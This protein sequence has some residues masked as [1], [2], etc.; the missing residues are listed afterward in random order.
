MSTYC[1]DKSNKPHLFTLKTKINGHEV[2]ILVDGGADYTLISNSL[3][4]EIKEFSCYHGTVTLEINAV[5]GCST[6][7]EAKVYSMT[8]PTNE[9][10]INIT[11]Y[12]LAQVP[13]NS[14]EDNTNDICKVWPNLND[15]IRQ[16]VIG[17]RFTGPADI[18]IG[19]DNY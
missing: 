16:Q 2:K 3:I 18:L 14:E 10:E 5:A 19:Q 15:T 4:H 8:I 13:A 11:G 9:T 12:R 17:N 1:N 7:A 6:T